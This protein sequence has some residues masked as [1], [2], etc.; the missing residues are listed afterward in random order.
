V[1]TA[2][3]EEIAFPSDARGL[4]FEPLGADQIPEQRNVHVVVS[5]PGAVRGNHLHER[6]TEIAVML[7]PGLVRLREAGQI[8]DVEV[9]IG[10]AF[11]FTLPAGVSH[12]FKATGNTPMLLVA[13]NTARFDPKNPDLIRDVLI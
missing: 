2:T 3:I 6:S 12:A 5:Q 1:S 13:F 10:K 7:G 4:V 9:P 11:R 8:R